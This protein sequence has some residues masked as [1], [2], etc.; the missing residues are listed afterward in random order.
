MRLLPV[1]CLASL[2]AACGKSSTAPNTG[3]Y[4]CESQPFPTTA[5]ASITVSGVVSDVASG[6]LAGVRVDAFKTGTV[7]S[8][9]STTTDAQGT[10]SLTV[11]TGGTPLDGYVKASHSGYLDTYA[12][13]SAPLPA[14][15]SI[16]LTVVTPTEFSFLATQAGVSPTAGNGSLAIRPVDCS[17]TSVPTATVT[18]NPA[19]TPHSDGSGDFFEF[20][21]A[22]GTVSVGA[23][24]QGHTFHSHPVVAV[25][26]AVTITV[27]APGPLSPPE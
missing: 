3:P 6:P 21:L 18:T 16:A 7:G 23:S 27:V 5:P 15:A 14:D 12:F 2:L 4:P 20:N 1:L 8:I 24:Y 17:G 19:S 9:D 22:P 13:P 10:F 26:D 25:A 11:A